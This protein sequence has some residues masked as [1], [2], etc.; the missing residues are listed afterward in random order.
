MLRASS[1]EEEEKKVVFC[2]SC[3]EWVK[4]LVK[5]SRERETTRASRKG[6]KLL[7]FGE[8]ISSSSSSCPSIHRRGELSEHA[9]HHE[10]V[11]I[12]TAWETAVIK[13]LKGICSFFFALKF[14][15]PLLKRLFPLASR[16]VEKKKKESSE[17]LLWR[18]TKNVTQ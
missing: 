15:L 11:R 17:E 1:S 10:N 4:R 14:A 7:S 13:R 16:T 12:M 5:M 8:S 6:V 2:L 9:S 3:D 18:W